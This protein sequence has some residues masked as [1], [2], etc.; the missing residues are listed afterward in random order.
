MFRANCYTRY[1]PQP[2]LV[3]LGIIFL[4]VSSTNPFGWHSRATGASPALASPPAQNPPPSQCR[5]CI[6]PAEKSFTHEG[7]DATVT[8]TAPSGCAWAASSDDNF[9]T[10]T[11]GNTGQGN[12]AVSFNVAANTGDSRRV[13]SLTIAGHTFA[14]LQ[15]VQFSDVPTNHLF[16][17]EIGKLSARG[18]TLGCGGGNYCPDSEVTREQMAALIIRGLGEFNPP[19]PAGQR[20]QDVPPSNIFYAFIDRLAALGINTQNFLKTIQEKIKFS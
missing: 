4:V 5:Y 2:I 14:V 10:A 11:S 6:S 15:G 9:I 19:I 1:R 12:G 20:F 18:I 3:L 13:G 17:A 7:G 8:V 16:F